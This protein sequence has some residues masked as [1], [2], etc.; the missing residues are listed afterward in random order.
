MKINFSFLLARKFINGK[1]ENG[2]IGFIS[3]SSTLGIALGVAVLI[4][5]LSVMNGFQRELVNRLLSFVPHV[6]LIAVEQ[7]ID[8]WES[9]LAIIENHP[10]VLAAAPLIKLTGMLQKGEKLKALEIRAIVPEF[11]QRVSSIKP[12]IISGDFSSISSKYNSDENAGIVI[13]QL[14]AKELNIDVGDE[15]QL[16]L[17]NKSSTKK[18]LSPKL[19]RFKVSAIFRLGGQLDGGLAYINLNQAR[20]LVGIPAD[21]V[22]GI[23]LKINDVFNAPIIAREIGLNLNHY[24]YLMDWLRTHGHL[25]QDIMLVK[26]IMYIALTL[27]IAVACFNIVSTLVMTVKE[28]QSEIAILK[29]MGI[30]DIQITLA[31]MFVG[32]INALMGIVIGIAFGILL[33]LN[34]TNIF[35]WL[36]QLSGETFLKQ[37]VYFIDFIPVELQIADVLIVPVI[38]LVLAL[39]ATLYP[40]RVATKA[41]PATVLG[42]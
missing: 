24:V 37:D 14:L 26:T 16:L 10:Q 19:A 30:K 3:K 39:L 5:A 13:G 9:K 34:L 28:K 18:L 8:N 1:H 36:E 33:T 38:A 7:P 41:D 35:K 4:I 2:F 31:F 42:Q 40:A 25:Y 11:E 22:S 6:E 32:M 27:V 15:V 20:A 17:P 23:R 12:Y 29:T 21:A